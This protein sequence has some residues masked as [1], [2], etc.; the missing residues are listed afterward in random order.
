MTAYA[1]HPWSSCTKL[2]NLGVVPLS[3]KES[4]S[5]MKI[6]AVSR[7]FTKTFHENPPTAIER[8]Y[9]KGKDGDTIFHGSGDCYI[10][11]HCHLL[12][13]HC[14]TKNITDLTTFCEVN[15]IDTSSVISVTSI[16]IGVGR[17]LSFI[18]GRQRIQPCGAITYGIWKQVASLT[19]SLPWVVCL[20]LGSSLANW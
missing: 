19:R 15:K 11:A 1:V 8:L 14:R 18:V 2:R 3:R 20:S 13:Q 17:S 12:N 9:A 5:G 7:A 4:I 16:V 6:M 10:D